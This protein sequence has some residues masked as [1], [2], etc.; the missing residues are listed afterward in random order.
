MSGQWSIRLPDEAATEALGRWLAS[1]L[2]DGLVT[3]EGDL[4]TGKTTLVRGWVRARGH[5]GPVPS[6]TYTLVEPYR[7]LPGK[8]LYHFDLYRLAEPEELYFIG[9]EEY[10]AQGALSLVEWPERGHGVLPAP[11]LRIHLERKG[12]T[13]IAHLTAAPDAG[14]AERIDHALA[15]AGFDVQLE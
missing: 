5:P 4:G 14:F 11:M 10:L 9:I 3:L 13:R 8:P 15:E 7:D 12:N 1:R 2:D 6:P